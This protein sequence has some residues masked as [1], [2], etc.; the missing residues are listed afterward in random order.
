MRSGP[1]DLPVLSRRDTLIQLSDVAHEAP[2]LLVVLDDQD[3]LVG[4]GLTGSVN[5]NVEP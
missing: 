4:H 3:A 2:A 5:V 1:G